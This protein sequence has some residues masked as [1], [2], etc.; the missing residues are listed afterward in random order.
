[1]RSISQ[2]D[3]PLMNRIH[4]TLVATAAV[5]GLGVTMAAPAFAAAVPATPAASQQV[6][7][8][9]ATPAELE[10]LA[11]MAMNNWAA[12]EAAFGTSAPAGV[13]VNGDWYPASLLTGAPW[14]ASLF[15]CTPTAGTASATLNM[16]TSQSALTGCVSPAQIQAAADLAMTN[17]ALNET[18]F[19]TSAPAGVTVNSVWY[20]AAFFNGT[21]VPLSISCP[22]T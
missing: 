8:G 20:P 7:N 1:M 2:K 11:T 3:K 14:A 16:A 22:A 12:N 4:K 9:C 10:T 6:F 17:W 13:T 18:N 19:G 15:T 21:N 5:A